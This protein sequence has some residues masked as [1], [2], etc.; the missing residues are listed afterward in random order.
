LRRDINEAER[1]I[2]TP[3]AII[4]APYEQARGLIDKTRDRS[5]LKKALALTQHFGGKEKH[6][7]HIM[8]RMEQVY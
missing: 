5:V 2:V 1:R 8:K 6:M 4:E 7:R 3:A